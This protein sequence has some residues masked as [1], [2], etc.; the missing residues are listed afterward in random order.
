MTDEK[1]DDWGRMA[2]MILAS[3]R[4]T[5]K[6]SGMPSV[7]RT[8]ASFV[9]PDPGDVP[10]SSKAGVDFLCG[11]DSVVRVIDAIAEEIE[12]RDYRPKQ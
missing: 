3:Y 2:D 6:F 10:P 1:T 7:L 8:L 4:P 9:R 12:C 5:N 11:V